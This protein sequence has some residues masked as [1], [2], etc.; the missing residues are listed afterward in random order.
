MSAFDEARAAC[1]ARWGAPHHVAANVHAWW[2]L[3]G[4]NVA[5]YA[6]ARDVWIDAFRDGAPVED[7][8]EWVLTGDDA[9]PL[10]DAIDAAARWMAERNDPTKGP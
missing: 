6:N 5:L 2:E 3:D 4:G 9:T 1:A 10:P 7:A 8:G